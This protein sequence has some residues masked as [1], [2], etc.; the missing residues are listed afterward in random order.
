VIEVYTLRFDGSCWPN[1]GGTAAKGFTLHCG[2]TLVDSGHKVVGTGDQMS[3]NVAEYAALNMGLESFL[4]LNHTETI[5][6]N[7]YGDSQLVINQMN[8]KWKIK[9]GLYEPYARKA[10][11]LVRKIRNHRTVIQFDWIPREKNE[12]CDILSKMHLKVGV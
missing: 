10:Q 3:N 2:S 6:L 4:K 12:E 9:E 5:Y 1:P 7:V 8:K 11:E